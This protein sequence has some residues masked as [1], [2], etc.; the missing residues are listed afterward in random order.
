MEDFKEGTH[1]LKCITK[2]PMF[3][4][5]T[6]EQFAFL[7]LTRCKVQFR[8]GETIFKQGTAMT[9]ILIV[10]DGLVKIYL[11]GINNHNLILNFTR[12]VSIISSPGLFTDFKHHFSS[13]AVEETSACFVD[14]QRLVEVFKQNK[15]FS[16]NLFKWANLH[17]QK[18]YKK[19]IELTQMGMHGRI[20][21][22]LLYLHNSVFQGKNESI[23]INRQDLA[24]M[25][26]MSKESSIRILKELKDENIIS[27]V[28]NLIVLNDIDRLIEISVKG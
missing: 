1:C 13:V 4:S 20:A 3:D 19:L 5:L 16:A 28:E 15:E 8:P 9:H 22:A 12:P 14:V 11:E 24:D 27:V 2:L 18:Y 21:G 17:T 10:T 7:N 6:E 26:A 25:T 23:K